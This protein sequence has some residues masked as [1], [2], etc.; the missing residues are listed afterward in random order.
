M[1]ISTVVLA[2]V[3]AALVAAAPAAAEWSK[4][5]LIS[6]SPRE[7]SDGVTGSVLSAD[8][9]YLVFSGS[10]DGRSGIFRRE[11]ATGTIEPVVAGSAYE[12]SP[13]QLSDHPSVSAE[14]R[15]VSFTTEAAL[16][17][18]DD[19]NETA[20][21]Y[22]RDMEAPAPVEGAPCAPV[23]PC[24]YTLVSAVDG[25]TQ[26]LTY[27]EAGGSV[28][29]RAAISADGTEVAFV[30]ESRSNLTA[31]AEEPGQVALRDLATERTTLVSS[32]RDPLTGGMTGEPVPGGAWGVAFAGSSFTPGFPVLSADGS[33]VAWS[34]I[35]IAAQVATVEG[36][37]ARKS[38]PGGGDEE[39]GYNE[40]LW[41]RIAEGPAAPTR[42]VVG[43]ADPEAPGCP[44]NGSIAE[45][46]CRGP[47][48]FYGGDEGTGYTAGWSQNGG[49]EPALSADGWTVATTGA[50]ITSPTHATDLFLVD[51]HPGRA[52]GE[53]IRRL[54]LGME[55]SLHSDPDV[56]KALGEIAISPD[57][58]RIA[59]ATSRREWRLTTP[60]LVTPPPPRVGS[61][62]LWLIDLGDDTL[63]RITTTVDGGPSSGEFGAEGASSPSFAEGGRELAFDSTASNLVAVDKNEAD[64][65][66]L[67]RDT[68][69]PGGSP[70]RSEISPPPAQRTVKPGWRLAL[71]AVSSPDGSV[72]ILAECPGAGSLRAAAVGTVSEP[73]W[74]SVPGAAGHRHRA[75]RQV[76]VSRRIATHQTKVAGAGSDVLVLRPASKLRGL[77]HRPGGLEATATVTFA[78]GGHAKLTETLPVRFRVH[79]KKGKGR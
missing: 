75:R 60:S 48:E 7:Q 54:T 28:S 66:F 46:A 55:V 41:R 52:P 12:F 49:S 17:P 39:F 67:S 10:I 63:R 74:V 29:G 15:F 3:L 38:V 47:Y 65:A 11:L 26:G 36:D 9:R 27:A 30:V 37:P 14:G 73:R 40:V 23:G 5:E 8:G 51:M 61:Q 56:H 33:T 22:V 50:P 19:H 4:P 78:A 2:L 31:G 21:V 64:D 71:R 32:T 35:D 18:A 13:V 62:E 42:R 1:R 57:G 24:A 43:A 45:A 76:P 6:V 25:G 58:S 68:T 77:S 16:D 20:D 70:G 72:R 44:P 69:L 34:A 59:L 79:H 53:S